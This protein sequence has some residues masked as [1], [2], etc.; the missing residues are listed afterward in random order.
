MSNTDNPVE[1][2]NLIA[3]AIDVAEDICDPFDGLVEK[4][5]TDPGA[6]FVADALQR[7]AALKNDDRAAF[8]VLRTQLKKVGCRVTALDEAIA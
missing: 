3:A 1:P 2:E 7:L 6:P 5:G 4:T 8:E